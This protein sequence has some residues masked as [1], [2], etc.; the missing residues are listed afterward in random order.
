LAESLMG[1]PLKMSDIPELKLQDLFDLIA[2][3]RK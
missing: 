1:S 3:S 2:R